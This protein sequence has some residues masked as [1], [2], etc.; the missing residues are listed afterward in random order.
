MAGVADGSKQHL[1]LLRHLDIDDE[2][3]FQPTI[4]QKQK[5]GRHVIDM[6]IYQ[7]ALKEFQLKHK[8]LACC[9]ECNVTI[10]CVKKVG[11]ACSVTLKCGQMRCG[12]EDSYKLFAVVDEK[13]PGPKRAA[14]NKQFGHAVQD[15][16]MGM[17]GA[18]QMFASLDLPPLSSSNCQRLAKL[19]NDEMIKVNDADMARLKEQKI[20]D[21]AV[22]GLTGERR[23]D[24]A[25]AVDTR[26]NSVRF[27]DGKKMGP[28]ATQ[29]VTTAIDSCSGKII[30]YVMENKVCIKGSRLRHRDSTAVCAHDSTRHDCS[31]TLAAD[32]N[33]QEGAMNTKIG[34]NLIT[35]GLAPITVTS[36]NDGQGAKPYAAIMGAAA[37][38]R[39]VMP[40][41]D[42][43]HLAGSQA[44]A[45]ERVSLR[46]ATFSCT[47]LKTVNSLKKLLAKDIKYRT[48]VIEL[49]IKREGLDGSQVDRLLHAAIECFCGN[50]AHCAALYSREHKL[51]CPG[52]SENNWML[53]SSLF[54]AADVRS[55]SCNDEEKEKLKEIFNIR[56][57]ASARLATAYGFNTQKNEAFNRSLSKNLPKGIL[58]SK[59]YNGRAAS[60]VHRYNNGHCKS[61]ESKLKAFGCPLLSTGDGLRRLRSQQQVI[62]RSL[63]YQ[64]TLLHL[65]KRAI[66]RLRNAKTWYKT[67]CLKNNEHDYCKGQNDPYKP[68]C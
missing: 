20:G 66:S 23:G 10:K 18:C 45:V 19:V 13:R 7:K 48:S 5:L 30:E 41:S 59:N 49:Q 53:Y 50:H 56:L 63:K 22:C 24:V 8:N 47:K 29:A 57:H 2:T 64:T 38:P 55:I 43:V 3:E 17:T 16:S 37:T 40:Q 14:I 54:K 67:K 9:D 52:S 60:A 11:L 61:I 32:V 15:S 46:K 27:G 28:S 25:I 42:P 21:N 33:I 51:G 39:A 4:L 58:F 44:R 34:M 36:D 31:A 65:K 68:L 12:F 26:Y 1:K 62:S 6:D 35:N